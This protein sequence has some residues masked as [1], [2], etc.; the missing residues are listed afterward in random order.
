MM[1]SRDEIAKQF[2]RHLDI[3]KS[4]LGKQYRNTKKCQ[5][6]YAGDFM[7]YEDAIT[8]SDTAGRAKKVMVKFNKVKPYVNAVKGFMAQNRRVQKYEARIQNSRIQEL[9]SSYANSIAKYVRDNADADQ[10][11]TQQDGDLLING[12]GAIE[13]ALS[14]GEGYATTEEDGQFICGRLD[15]LSV[16]WDP[17]A[18]ATNLLGARW[19]YS[20]KEYH[21]DDAKLLFDDNNEEHF[22][23]AETDDATAHEYFPNGGSYDKIAPY[24][25]A[26][27]EDNMVKVYFYQWYDIEPYFKVANP[28]Y[29]LQDPQAVQFADIFLQGLAQEADGEFDPRA[30]LLTFG[31]DLKAK[32]EEYF[33]DFLGE[34]FEFKR[35]VFYT[36][37]ISGEHVFTAYKSISQQGFTIQFKTGD[38]DAVN[39][40]WTGLVNSMME[41][42]L[43][44]N[45][46]L[47]ELMFTI[48]ANSKGGVYVEE[49]AVDDIAEFEHNYGKTDGVV[50]VNPG[51]LAAGKIQD[52]KSPHVPT[53]LDQIVNI[54]DQALP[55]V[56]GIDPSFLGTREFANDTYAYQRARIKR[57]MSVLACYFDAAKLY[58]KRN[59]RIMLDLMKVF[60]QNNENMTIRVVGE[61]GQAMFLRLS[62]KQLSA[63][64]DV[65]TEE[66]PLS[67]EDKQE[68]AGV[69]S[70]IGDKLIMADPVAAKTM[71]G[72]AVELMPLDF[73]MKERALQVLKPKE[74]EIDPAYVQQLEAQVKAL[75]DAGRQAQL[76]KT[77]ADAELTLARAEEAKRKTSKVDADIAKTQAETVETL[78]D[79]EQRSLENEAIKRSNVT[80][81]RIVL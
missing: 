51:A 45:K 53:G 59:A 60:V 52:K 5:A 73:S 25:Y 2:K 68:Q 46:A 78:E 27:K 50:K 69:L 13:T 67:A 54:A 6:F 22:E 41:P 28:L 12:Y 44:Y 26:N 38:Y 18:K 39:N 4:K 31:T 58:S 70:G 76:Q 79:S 19:V 56:N 16:G 3:S 77:I 11:E 20:C 81:V 65:Q 24:D 37:V 8:V 10:V 71:Y 1:K 32:L 74:G 80:D 29:Q 14:Y 47:T 61:Q 17:Y 35:K 43:Y 66:A 48:A 21:I 63:E 7:K 40:I 64:Y 33:G 72:M 62:E 42:G 49:D 23:E 34:V 15:P 36:A 75:M 30:E 9:F 57:V 55:D